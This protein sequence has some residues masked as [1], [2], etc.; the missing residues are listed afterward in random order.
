[1]SGCG[2]TQLNHEAFPVWDCSAAASASLALLADRLTPIEQISSLPVTVKSRRLNSSAADA[3][4]ESRTTHSYSGLSTLSARNQ[5]R[6]KLC[7]PV[8]ANLVAGAARLIA[9]YKQK[10][11]YRRRPQL[12]FP[13]WDNARSCLHALNP[14]QQPWLP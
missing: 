7:R 14:R 5:I 3:D 12:A 10:P 8:R 4:M 1:M 13:E 9:K 6:S 11:E 2:S